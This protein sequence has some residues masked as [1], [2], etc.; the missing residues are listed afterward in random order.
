MILFDYSF[1]EQS[2]LTR[3]AEARQAGAVAIVRYIAGRGYEDKTIDAHEVEAARQAG[4]GIVLVWQRAGRPDLAD[5]RLGYLDGLQA[6]QDA[7]GLGYPHGG[8][9]FW[10]CD[11]PG[12]SW[13]SC[14]P[15]ALG[16]AQAM[17]ETANRYRT[18][19]YGPHAV[20]TGAIA[21]GLAEFSWQPETWTPLDEQTADMVQMV[22]SRRTVWGGR[23]VDENELRRPLP[24]WLPSHPSALVIAGA[25]SDRPAVAAHPGGRPAPFNR[26]D[27]TMQL[28]RTPDGTL[29]LV[30]SG[31]KARFLDVLDRE[32]NTQPA[33]AL[34]VADALVQLGQLELTAH[35]GGVMAP[36]A[37]VPDTQ[38]G[39]A[40]LA[41][42]PWE[43]I[44]APDL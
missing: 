34:A 31:R 35:E 39:W 16:W 21:E 3:L 1:A 40:A 13:A 28:L 5:A 19:V 27:D 11:T 44:Y 36:W 18:G 25:D 43:S 26:E 33:D 23:S 38:A 2:L 17:A 7:T 4:I 30:R 37:N 8:V 10:T 12:A 14:R 42:I 41:L 20:W 24:V 15:Y 6:V 32:A 9:I 22:N 29:F